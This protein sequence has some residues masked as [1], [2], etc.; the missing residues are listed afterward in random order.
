MFR[1]SRCR[2]QVNIWNTLGR[3]QI[4]C[5]RDFAS[6]KFLLSDTKNLN[7]DA[8]NMESHDICQQNSSTNNCKF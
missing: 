3:I 4:M 8:P 1:P 5:R 2:L 6:Y 7:V